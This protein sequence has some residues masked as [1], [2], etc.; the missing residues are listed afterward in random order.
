MSTGS[1]SLTDSTAPVVSMTSSSTPVATFF[2]TPGNRGI[3]C[4]AVIGA[5]TSVSS[6][7]NTRLT[8]RVGF[9]GGAVIVTVAGA[10]TTAGGGGAG[11][12]AFSLRSTN[13][14]DS[15]L[16]SASG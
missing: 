8:S 11:A 13:P 9:A 4:L 14:V 7:E 2:S 15:V 6:A 10:D 5:T 3:V 12:S 16:M 1:T